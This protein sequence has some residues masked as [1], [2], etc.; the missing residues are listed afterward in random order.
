MP[1]FLSKQA[2]PRLL[3]IITVLLL[4]SAMSAINAMNRNTKKERIYNQINGHS[5]AIEIIG[6]DEFIDKTKQALDLLQ[7]GSPDA[8]LKVHKYIGIIEQGRHSA[9]WAFEEPPRF[10][11]NDVTAFYSATWYAGVLAHE[12]VHSE[13][14]YQ[15]LAGGKSRKAVPDQVWKER[16][17]EILCMKY[18]AQVLMQIGSPQH[19][20]DHV[21]LRSGDGT[22]S[23]IDKDGDVDWLDYLRRDW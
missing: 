20:V 17:A 8:F 5:F 2:M 22:H 1:S 4:F 11:V 15:Y 12:S 21:T 19:E 16:E 3:L 13:L 6:S 10:E 14:F 23:D 9:M 7:N 18:Q